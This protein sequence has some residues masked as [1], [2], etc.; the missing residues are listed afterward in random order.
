MQTDIDALFVNLRME[1]VILKEML[2]V[3]WVSEFGIVE[4]ID[5]V[6]EEYKQTRGL[7]PIRICILGPP[8]VGK[9]T[10]AEKIC[11]HYK[12]HHIKVK[13]AITESIAHLETLVQ[14]EDGENESDEMG[15]AQE[16]LEALK[17]NMD[18]NGGRLDDQFVI[19]IMRDKLNSTPCKN[20][21]FVLDGFPKT[22][23]QAKELFNADED[24]P[25]GTRAKTPLFNKNMIPEYILSL[26]A[27]DA[28]LKNRVL[29]LPESAVDGTH[30]T[31]D[32]F[33]RHLT[34]FRENNVEDETVLNYFDELEIH[35][36]HIEITSSDDLEYL[37]VMEKI[38]EVVGDA[39]NYG[40]TS[41]ELEAEERRNA[42]E[43]LQQLA[44]EKAELE[45]Q[46]AVEAAN[47]AARWEEW[48]KHMEEVQKVEQDFLEAQTAP[49]RNYLM[50]TVMPTLTQGLIECCKS[51]PEDPV[52][53]LAEYLFKNNPQV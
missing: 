43:R 1:A 28:F 21:G 38:I 9:S 18:Q 12:L 2:N 29:N 53:F 15:S 45:R 42:D 10:V 5:H 46:E 13:D 37:V 34:S 40:L 6:V 52:D 24:E 27:T 3:H 47:K 41:D 44:D 36:E 19:R 33:P 23:D 17:E 50:K 35:L 11:K 39:R 30:Y 20:Q 16:F 49:L 7:L 26:N 8:A 4:N 22:Y 25:E 14:M 31:Q 48:S 32:Q 51:K